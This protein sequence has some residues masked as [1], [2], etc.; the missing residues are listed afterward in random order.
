[1]GEQCHAVLCIHTVLLG[2]QIPMFFDRH[3]LSSWGYSSVVEHSTADREVPG[4]NPGAPFQFYLFFY[5]QSQHGRQLREKL[6]KLLE[7]FS[8]PLLKFTQTMRKLNQY[9]LPEKISVCDY[10]LHLLHV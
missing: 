8:D 7:G 10:C 4:S 6:E 3:Y 2:Q 1:M 5:L 9:P